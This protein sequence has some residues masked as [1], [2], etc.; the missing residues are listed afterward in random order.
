MARSIPT[1]TGYSTTF[2]NV[3]ETANRGIDININT[4]NLTT[5]DFQW[6]SNI[7][8]S[9]Q[10]DKIVTLSNGKQDDINN[11]W[12]IGKPNGIIYGFASNGMWQYTDTALMRLFALNGNTF[13][14]GQVRPIDQNGD[15]KA[16]E[17]SVC[18]N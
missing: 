12:F 1:V 4:I 14:P 10:R 13:S 2:Q 3:G 16:V 17:I 7:N 5:K 8:A 18:C 6:T 11:N 15:N 9:W